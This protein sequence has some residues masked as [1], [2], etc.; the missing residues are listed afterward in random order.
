MHTHKIIIKWK[1]G[2][3]RS[4]DLLMGEPSWTS[5]GGGSANLAIHCCSPCISP[6]PFPVGCLQHAWTA[7]F[8]TNPAAGRRGTPSPDPAEVFSLSPEDPGGSARLSFGVTL[9]LHGWQEEN[10]QCKERAVWVWQGLWGLR[11]ACAW[12]S[13][14]ADRDEP[15]EQGKSQPSTCGYSGAGLCIPLPVCTGSYS[16]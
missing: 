1:G 9:G 4:A 6:L 14:S 11:S 10:R 3:V 8:P 2:N 5:L 13:S 15:R 7:Q 12:R 16:A